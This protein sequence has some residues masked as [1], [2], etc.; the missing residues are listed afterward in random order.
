MDRRAALVAG[1]LVTAAPLLAQWPAHRT[2][3][4]PRTA[5]GKVNMQGPV[6]RTRAGTPDLSGIWENIGWR[7]LQARSNDVS[8]TGGS[9]GTSPLVAAAS[10]VL[11][12]GPG[13]FFDIGAGVA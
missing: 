12:S 1:L 13:L 2:A 5:D 7:E 8:G 6:P 10:G 11:T 3:G 4:A 9:P